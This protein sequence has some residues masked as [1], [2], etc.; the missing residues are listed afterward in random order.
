MRISILAAAAA[1]GGAAATIASSSAAT[2][3]SCS[4]PLIAGSVPVGDGGR[5]TSWNVISSA[6]GTGVTVD[7]TGAIVLNHNARA[8]LTSACT[9]GGSFT[10]ASYANPMVLLG[11]QV[12]HQPPPP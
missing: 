4:G 6:A 12:R 3:A 11:K 8:Y 7:G 1:A 9:T 10:P 2:V 5:V